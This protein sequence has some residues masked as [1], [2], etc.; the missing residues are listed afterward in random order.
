MAV[1]EAHAAALRAFL[2]GD[3]DGMT[4]HVHQLGEKA[5]PRF[6]QLAEAAL[7]VAARRWFGPAFTIGD[8]VRYVAGVR[9]ARMAD[10][11]DL[12]F[13]PA[14]GENV[15]RASLGQFVPMP[16][17]PGERFRA[18]VALLDA[19]AGSE[20]HSATDVDDLLILARGLADRWLA[21]SRPFKWEH[22]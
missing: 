14:V 16:T 5:M 21:T 17:D 20:L 10:G 12:G 19:L 13:D 15:L 9:I 18:V 8:L 4:L 1:T 2:V 22:E 11:D 7:S 6:L 3:N